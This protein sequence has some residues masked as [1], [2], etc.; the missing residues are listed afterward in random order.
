MNADI[1]AI[2]KTA[3]NNNPVLKNG[4]VREVFE[5]AAEK[6]GTEIEINGDKMIPMDREY[7]CQ[8]VLCLLDNAAKYKTEDSKTVVK[9]SP[10]DIVISNRTGKDKFTPG[11]GIA[12]AERILEHHKLKLKTELKDGVFEAR[13][14]KNS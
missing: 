12:I 9:I 1:E 4:S 11:T 6:T 14:S 8:A 5:E 3:E 2:L 13:I 7:F 10:K